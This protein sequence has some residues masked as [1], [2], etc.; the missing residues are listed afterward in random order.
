MSGKAFAQQSKKFVR[1]DQHAKEKKINQKYGKLPP[2]QAETNPWYKLYVELIGPY[3]IP[4]K[5]KNPL[6]L[7]CLTRIDPATGWFEMAQIPNKTAA[8]I[9]DINK[10][11]LFT[12]Y[13]LP[14]QIVFNRGTKFMAE[15]AKMCQN[16][17]FLKRKPTTI[18]NPS[19][20]QSSNESIKL[21]E[22]SSA[23]L[24]CLTSLTTIH[25]QES[26]PLLS[27]L[28]VQLITQNYKHLQFS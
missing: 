2:K 13:P 1:S 23:N 9:A 25:G 22:I 6:E 15:F 24:M 28:S 4:Q 18:R 19:P 7:W 27:L 26:Y 5:V 10:K 16:K 21:L 20:M 12:C 11:I 14:Q 8:D 3:T 17:Y